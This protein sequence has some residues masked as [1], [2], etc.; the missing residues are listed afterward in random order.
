MKLLVP[1]LLG[2]LILVQSCTG[3]KPAALKATASPR[4][5]VKTSCS[6]MVFE[7][8]VLSKKNIL[9]IFDCSGWA[10]KY[11]DLNNVIKKS[12]DAAIDSTL[13]IFN[14]TFFSSKEKRKTLYEVVATAEGQGE[15]NAL[16]TMLQKTL[17]EHNVV[18]QMSNVLTK[19][20]ENRSGPAVLMNFV[21]ASNEENLKNISALKSLAE[22]YA[23]N[24]KLINS[25]LSDE[26]KEKLVAQGKDLVSELSQKMEA[27]DWKF[28]ANIIHNQ[29]SPVQKWAIGGLE[30]DLNILLNIVEEP[31]F[32][33]DVTF[34]KESLVKGVRCKNRS[35]QNDFSINIGQELKHKIESLKNDNKEDFERVLLHGLTKY[36]AF[37]EFCEE[38]EQQQGLRSFYMVL[39]H[40]FNAI[41]SGHDYKF[42]KKIHQLL[43]EDRFSFVSFLSSKSF[44][45]LRSLLLDLKLDENDGPFVRSLYGVLAELSQQ[46]LVAFS[47][48]INEVSIEN[49]KTQTWLKA[50]SNIWVNLQE[51]EKDELIK[52]LGAFLSEEVNTS[53][54]LHFTES[55][56]VSFPEMSPALS[57]NLSNEKFQKDTQYIIQ[58]LAEPKIQ[59]DLAEFLSKKGIFELIEIMTQEYVP[60]TQAPKTREKSQSLPVIYV[61]SPQTKESVQTRSC[62]LELT[63]KY[64]NNSSY[65]NLVNTLPESCLSVLGK[66]GFVGQIYLWMNSSESFFKENYQIDDFHSATGVWSPGMLQFIF[67]S[68]VKADFTLH[69]QSGQAGLK[70][71]LNEIH[72]TFTD[73]RLL[74]AFHQFSLLFQSIDQNL[75]LDSRILNFVN[76]QSDAELNQITADGFKLLQT[77]SPFLKVAIKKNSCLDLNQALGAN[78]CLDRN[79]WS[80]DF[81]KLFRLLKRKNEKNDSLIKNLIS[82]VHPKGGI[83]IPFKKN[84]KSLHQTSLD[85]IVRFVYDLSDVKTNKNLI[86][87]KLN[88]SISTQGTVIDRLEVVIRDISFLNNF[89][90]A[91]FMN[92]V[93]SAD[94]YRDEVSDSE[95]LLKMLDGSGGVLRGLH[96]FPADTKYRLK[97]IRQTYSSLVEVSD[98]Y[99]QS[100]GTSRTYGSFIQS[101]L[102]VIGNSSSVSTQNFNAYRAPKVSLVDGHNGQFLTMVV[103]MSGLRRLSQFVRTRFDSKLSVLE[104]FAFKK[105]NKNLIARHDLT[106]IQDRLQSILDKYLDNNK[107]QLNLMIEDAV[108]FVSRLDE[109]EQ[110]SLEEIVAKVLVLLSDERVSNKNIEKLGDLIELSIEM[111]PE[112]RKIIS[113]VEN[114]KELLALINRILDNCLKYPTELNHLA[115]VVA[116]SK[117]INA[118]D[119][120]VL[121]ADKELQKNLAHFLN[122]LLSMSDFQ[123]NLNWNETFQVMFSPGDMRWESLKF[124][125]QDAV[126]GKEHKLSLSLLISVLGEKNSDGYRFKGIMDELFMHHRPEIEQF[127]NET[128][129][130]LQ[131]KPD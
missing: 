7:G 26:A 9:N 15:L 80:D 60:P 72:R 126:G 108:S 82:W 89:Y 127:L 13:K 117:L 85:E 62:F 120:R 131:L 91:Y 61:E 49:S 87:K 81:L 107:N 125:L 103:E 83:A 98:H 30:G 44:L 64:E 46:D 102:T 17:L 39:K 35:G 76:S 118:G 59:G 74:E 92:M 45:N 78:T 3:Q 129:K 115:E 56:I 22:A 114:K 42:L 51:T 58:L 12:D 6:S 43:G 70:K 69:N 95:K 94:N 25:F 119:L 106:G 38:K 14:D 16:A 63:T 8:Q 90:G 4:R 28:L 93:A 130:S 68:A 36:L 41:P 75:G 97:N 101:L 37:E 19:E 27:K 77:S 116:S 100:D 5:A 79:E 29:D 18:G 54:V 31:N 128:F 86:Y 104:S 10:K 99:L 113:E 123:T 21:S 67:S 84:K 57:K 65:Y 47:K 96:T 105:V 110:K 124:W 23:S 66:V 34:F 122:Q 121:L 88:S 73:I 2:M 11:P 20:A 111:W 109:D 50:W 24:K 1:Y 112:F 32:Y 55:M 33:Q 52:F 71:N 48:L 53:A 40:A